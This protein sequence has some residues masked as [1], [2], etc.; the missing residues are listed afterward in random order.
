M[1]ASVQSPPAVAANDNP[2]GIAFLGAGITSLSAA[3]RA[4][5]NG[6]DPKSIVIYEASNRTGGKIQTGYLADG[7]HVNMGA[8]FID[9]DHT[10]LIARAQELGVQLVDSNNLDNEHFQLF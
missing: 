3:I 1:S 9:S 4:I 6:A 10:R 2:V 8:E 5:E 7:T